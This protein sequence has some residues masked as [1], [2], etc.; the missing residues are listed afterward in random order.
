MIHDHGIDPYQLER[1]RFQRRLGGMIVGV[2]VALLA[3][4]TAFTAF[5]RTPAGHRLLADIPIERW[6]YEGPEQYVRRIE[7]KSETGFASSHPGL[8]AEFVPPARK[9]GSKTAARA[10]DLHAQPQTRQLA[11]TEGDSDVNRL[12][13]ARAQR[14]NLPLVRSEDLV[15]EHLV[16]PDYPEEARDRNIEGKVAVLALVDTTGSVVSVE[17]MNADR[18]GLLEHAAAEAVWKC[19]VRPYRVNGQVQDVYAMFRFAFRIY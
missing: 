9:G 19:R 6:G 3:L 17:V 15:I 11:D 1:Q 2:S 14:A 18:E 12:A 13:R 8:Q 16:R 7:L 5:L 4:E 10:H